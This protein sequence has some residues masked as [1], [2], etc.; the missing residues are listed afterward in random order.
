[1][2]Y[3]FKQG[4]KTVQQGVRRIA[5]RELEK[6][7]EAID[8]APDVSRI[9]HLL[10]KR[11]KKL[12]GLIRL[13]RPGFSGY[14]EENAAFREAARTLSDIRDA[15]VMTKAYDTLMEANRGEV[16]RSAM[17]PV[18]R[19]LTIRLKDA[20]DADALAGRLD[21]FRQNM[22]AAQQRA[23]D[24]LIEDK[25]FEAL[26]PGLAKTFGRARNAMVEAREDRTPEKMHE[27]RKRVKYHGYHA[28]LLEPAFREAMAA[29]GKATRRL[30]SL[31]GD[32]HD[33]AVFVDTLETFEVGD[34][35]R[36]KVLL[37]LAR[38]R[39]SIIETEA[40]PLGERLFAEG[41][42]ELAARWARWWSIWRGEER[43]AVAA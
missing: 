4:D 39:Q 5:R 26:G 19:A 32:H 42:D 40:F 2:A 37:R 23:R 31:L 3:Q 41:A 21:L 30:G 35:E 15:D 34:G 25:E 11:C 24:W 7:V 22:I 14:A 12:R 20:R 29:H 8:D 1:M 36:R 18:R 13:V 16:D 33:L 6:A 27:W 43:F 10:H 28:R 17:A 38:Q 9:I